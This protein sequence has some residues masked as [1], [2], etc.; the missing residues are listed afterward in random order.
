MDVNFSTQ[1]VEKI[2]DYL[3]K[4]TYNSKQIKINTNE[5][6]VNDSEIRMRCNNEPW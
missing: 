6:R 5:L 2:N 4:D 3:F 1:T